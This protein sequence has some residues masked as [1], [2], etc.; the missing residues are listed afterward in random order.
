MSGGHFDHQQYKLIQ[1]S[2]E[3]EHSLEVDAKQYEF[4]EETIHTFKETMQKLNE[5]F[6]Y[7]QRIDWFLSGDD[8]EDTFHK[9]LKDDL[10]KLNG[11]N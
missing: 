4:S 3:I 2:D 10:E 9:R 7:I 8:S 5:A 1:I 6:V 11:E